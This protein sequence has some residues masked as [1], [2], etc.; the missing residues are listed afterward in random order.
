MAQSIT[1]HARRVARA[2]ITLVPACVAIAAMR[3]PFAMPAFVQAAYFGAKQA[4]AIRAGV[5]RRQPAAHS[6]A[7]AHGLDPWLLFVHAKYRNTVNSV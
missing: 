4:W 7:T 3:P 2:V 5:F 6:D 1:L